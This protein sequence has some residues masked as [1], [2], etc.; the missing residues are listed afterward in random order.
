MHV[1]EQQVEDPSNGNT[2]PQT[3]GGR[4]NAYQRKLD[5]QIDSGGTSDPPPDNGGVDL[6]NLE[7]P[8]IGGFDSSSKSILKEPTFYLS[9]LVVL[10]ASALTLSGKPIVFSVAL[11][12]MLVLAITFHILAERFLFAD[13]QENRTLRVPGEGL[14]VLTFGSIL[15]GLS[16]LSYAVYAMCTSN[17]NNYLISAGKIALLLVVPIFNFLVWRALRKGYLPRP[18]LTG[19]MN[20]V[21]AGLSGSWTMI[22]MKCLVDV[23]LSS[24]CKFGWMLLLFMSPLMMFAAICLAVDLWKKTEARIGLIS[25]VFSALG[26]V[27]SLSFVLAP[28]GHSLFVQSYLLDARNA[29]TPSVQAK[30]ISTLREIAKKEDLNPSAYPLSDLGLAELLVPNRG[31]NSGVEADKNL[32]FRITGLPFDKGKSKDFYENKWS[33]DYFFA[34]SVIGAKMPGLS[35]GKSQISGSIDSETLTCSMNWTMIFHNSG[36]QDQEARAEMAL[37]AGAVVSRVTLWVDGKPQEGAFAPTANVRGAYQEVVSRMKDPLLVTMSGRDRILLQCFPVPSHG[38]E[39]KVRIGIKAPLNVMD[40][41]SCSVR[42]PRLLESNFANPKRHRIHLDS[43]D[44]M[45]AEK[46]GSCMTV[47]KKGFRLDAVLRDKTGD[48]DSDL[49]SIERINKPSEISVVDWYSRGKRFITEKIENVRAFVP[50][51]L[52][53]VIDSSESLRDQFSQIKVALS[54]LPKSLSPSVFIVPQTNLSGIY[55]SELKPKKLAEVLG[56]SP[57]DFVGGRNNN[58]ELREAL[59]YASERSDSA[60]LWIHG[61]QP[62]NESSIE[63]NALD[64]VHNVHLYDFEVQ[65]GPNALLQSL[66]LE[67]CGSQINYLPVARKKDVQGDL[68]ILFTSW[69]SPSKQTVVVRSISDKRPASL[70][71]DDGV[72]A[73][74]TALWAKSETERLISNGMRG[75]AERLASTYRIITPVSGAVVMASAADYESHKL[76]P[77]NYRNAP[78]GINDTYRGMTKW[79]R[80]DITGNLVSNS[81]QLLRAATGGGFV[82]APVDPRYGQ[83]NEVGQLADYGYDTARDIARVATFLSFIVSIVFGLRIASNMAKKDS[84]G[85]A[86]A[87]GV[88]F[89]LFLPTVVHL[90]GSFF[91]NNFGGLGGGL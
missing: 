83:S 26:C 29:S 50:K 64:L 34:S 74:V 24:H 16:L 36:L 9:I 18:R 5:E 28:I 52:I 21:A 75:P 80:D 37:P 78:E 89:T 69:Q 79:F 7:T 82:G 57:A 62:S 63:N 19:F 72:S 71:S 43:R 4:T 31:L 81:V 91:I 42:L 58:S 40:S 23:H 13:K 85:M 17:Q 73:Q 87:K 12:A 15:P 11:G 32:F 41:K 14:F 22:W 54:A 59:D 56:L 86:V 70:N 20:G 38:G 53:V 90:L 76:D 60:V 67:G 77:G 27:L 6:D 51:K 55:D 84:K 66:Y 46:I 65:P 48:R 3:D 88:A 1:H 49:I 45:A 47:P 25:S 30:A 35:L 8:K 33:T 44:L 10:I 2:S 68:K 61:P 39:M